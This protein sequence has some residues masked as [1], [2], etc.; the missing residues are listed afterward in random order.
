MLMHNVLI[1][2]PYK[3]TYYVVVLHLVDKTITAFSFLSFLSVHI[4]YV[5]NA[6]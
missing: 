2:R 1:K 3:N 5:W 4:K 6:I